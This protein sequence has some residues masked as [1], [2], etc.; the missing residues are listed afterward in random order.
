MSKHNRFCFARL[1]ERRQAKDLTWRRF[2]RLCQAYGWPSCSER[3]L[4]RL[5]G[6]I[7]PVPEHLATM[8]DALGCGVQ[9]LC[10]PVKGERG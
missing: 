7:Q 6:G 1:D 5:V 3:Y 9:D 4:L 10:E 2:A 8:A